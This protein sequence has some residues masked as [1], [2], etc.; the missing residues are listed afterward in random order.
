MVA[1][2]RARTFFFIQISKWKN[3]R[4][5]NN[6]HHN[7]SVRHGSTAISES[8]SSKQK[9]IRLLQKNNNHE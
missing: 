1:M 4:G 3:E 5:R 8:F 9:F 7:G 2:L 6:Y